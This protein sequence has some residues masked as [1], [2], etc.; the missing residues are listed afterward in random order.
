MFKPIDYFIKKKSK[1]DGFDVEQAAALWSALSDS[2]KLKF[3]RKA[4]HARDE[5]AQVR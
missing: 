5:Y 1:E 4:E 2:K 3:I